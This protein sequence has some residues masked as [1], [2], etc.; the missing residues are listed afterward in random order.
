MELF[1]QLHANKSELKQVNYQV[2][3]EK[4]KQHE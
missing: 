1:T 4:T 3:I 2:D